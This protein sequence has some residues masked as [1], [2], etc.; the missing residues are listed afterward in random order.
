MQ[1]N[2][3]KKLA[4]EPELLSYKNYVAKQGIAAPEDIVSAANAIAKADESI[5]SPTAGASGESLARAGL[6]NGGYAQYLS[7]A[8]KDE[9]NS[10]I[11]KAIRQSAVSDYN[12]RKSYGKYIESYNATQSKLSEGLIEKLV[13]ENVLDKEYAY[14]LAKQAGLSDANALYTAAQ[15]VGKAK[16][17]AIVDVISYA[18]KNGLYPYNAKGYAIKIGLDEVSA[19]LVYNAMKYT[20]SDEGIDY[21]S[22]TPDQYIE[23]L[24]DRLKNKN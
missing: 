22:L 15:G 5:Y 21:E 2:T 14:R 16:R 1:V 17:K 7:K 4:N 12:I 13:K 18:K 6:L 24:K 11:A 3:I 20:D 8:L 19:N 23:I 10:D 9:I